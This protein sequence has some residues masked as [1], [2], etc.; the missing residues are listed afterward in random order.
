MRISVVLLVV[1][2]VA[3]SNLVIVVATHQVY[4]NKILSPL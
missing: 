2:V 3:T 4:S 1:L